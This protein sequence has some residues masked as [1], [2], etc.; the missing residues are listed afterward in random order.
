M[1]TPEE[2]DFRPRGVVVV[3][4]WNDVGTGVG[5]AE[6]LPGCGGTGGGNSRCARLAF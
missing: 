4:V 3:G 2:L 6:I 5:V 1:W